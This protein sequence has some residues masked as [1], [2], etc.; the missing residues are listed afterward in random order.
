MNEAERIERRREVKRRCDAAHREQ[1]LAAYRQYYAENQEELRAKRRAYYYAHR[2]EALA[3]AKEYTARDRDKARAN[4][5]R[6]HRS[7]RLRVLNHFG[8]KC[9]WPDGCDITDP[10]ML[11]IDHINGD[12]YKHRKERKA[13]AHGGAS[14]HMWLIKNNFPPGFRI[15]CANHNWKHRAN[16]ARAKEDNHE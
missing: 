7:I 12:G 9:Q 6:Y 10:D 4:Y 11:Q 14:L 8:G 16:M 2:D 15:L 3:Y 13:S 1:R 5:R